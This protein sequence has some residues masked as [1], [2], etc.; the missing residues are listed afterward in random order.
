MTCWYAEQR[1]HMQNS[2]PVFDSKLLKTFPEDD[3]LR[4]HMLKLCLLYM[5]PQDF[6]LVL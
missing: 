4:L 3:H 2:A 6:V 1:L 5:L